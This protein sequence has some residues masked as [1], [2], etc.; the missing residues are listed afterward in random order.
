MTAAVR[1]EVARAVRERKRAIRSHQKP[2]QAIRSH[3]KP[4]ESKPRGLSSEHAWSEPRGHPSPDEAPREVQPRRAVPSVSVI[5][6]I[7]MR[8]VTL[9]GS[10]R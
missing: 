4:S 3:Q 10:R 6:T 5:A 9:K 7:R 2:S 8:S 1:V